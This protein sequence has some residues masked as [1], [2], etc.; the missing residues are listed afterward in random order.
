MLTAT[1]TSK[2]YIIKPRSKRKILNNN[3]NQKSLYEESFMDKE[4]SN[5]S[6]N[7]FRKNSG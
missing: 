3:S 7:N 2:S 5:L 1:P 4:N 6:I